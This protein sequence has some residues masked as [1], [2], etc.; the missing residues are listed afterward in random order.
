MTEYVR[1][2]EGSSSERNAPYT[3][4]LASEM[5]W[6][7]RFYL[8]PFYKFDSFAAPTIQKKDTIAIYAK[9]R[10]LRKYLAAVAAG[11]EYGNKAGGAEAH[12]KCDGID[13]P[14]EPY[15]FQIPNP[16]STRLDAILG[17]KSKNNAS[18]IYFCLAIATVLDHLLND[19]NSWAYSAP[20]TPLFRSVNGDGITPLTG[21]DERIDADA[22]FRQVQKQRQ[23]NNT[24]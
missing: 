18:L 7:K 22:I 12:A 4:K 2:L 8:L 23:K 5:H 10:T 16:L 19:E 11:I 20:S 24:K 6:L 17:P 1:I 13:N 9:T 15:V 3:R 21:V 14:W